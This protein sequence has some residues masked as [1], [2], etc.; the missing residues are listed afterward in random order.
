MS[1]I[2][3][4]TALHLL[5]IQL[6]FNS[7]PVFSIT[8]YFKYP[9]WVHHFTMIK[10][11][12]S[13][14]DHGWDTHVRTLRKAGLG[15][16]WRNT[17]SHEAPVGPA[18]ANRCLPI[19]WI[20]VHHS[21]PR[22]V[23]WHMQGRSPGSGS[24]AVFSVFPV[25]FEWLVSKSA[26]PL[27][28]RDRSGLAP[29]SLLPLA[30][31]KSTLLLSYCLHHNIGQEIMSMLVLITIHACPDLQFMYETLHFH[32]FPDHSLWIKQKRFRSAKRTRTSTSSDITTP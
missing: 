15:F 31:C 12:K 9:D 8:C 11:K 20:I 2:P 6:R 24:S 13:H 30:L 18:E 5:R 1:N 27:Q 19:S 3:K 4:C 14:P 17:H 7:S 22:R 32:T 16:L 23:W 29:D 21:F 28:W 10:T 25:Q 26:S